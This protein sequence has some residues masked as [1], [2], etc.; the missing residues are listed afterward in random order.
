M[1]ANRSLLSR[2]RTRAT[3]FARLLLHRVVG[4]TYLERAGSGTAGIHAVAAVKGPQAC[5]MLSELLGERPERV[6]WGSRRERRASSASARDDG[7][8]YGGKLVSTGGYA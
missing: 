2:F 6:G 8:F 3:A 4:A 7:S 5:H 1:V